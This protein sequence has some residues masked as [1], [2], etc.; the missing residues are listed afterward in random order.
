M[1]S[2][3]QAKQHGRRVSTDNPAGGDEGEAAVGRTTAGL[4]ARAR[5]GDAEAYD[6]LFALAADRARLFVR[7]RLGGALRAKMDVED[8]LQEA[9]L[10][11]HRSFDTFRYQGDGAFA[12]WLCRIIENRIR[13]LADHHG[14]QK[15]RPPGALERVSRIEQRVAVARTGPQTAVLRGERSSRLAEAMDALADDEREVLLLR[16]FQDRTLDQIAHL[17]GRSPS[18]VRRLLGRATRQ[19]G[20]RLLADGAA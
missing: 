12:R 3:R 16:F 11:A 5:S 9:Y 20:A 4:V 18:A 13:G 1:R 8:V 15:R 10:E 7:L 17:T 19:L 2:N 6:A 14:A